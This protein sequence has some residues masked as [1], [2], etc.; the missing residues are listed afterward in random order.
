[1]H[2]K[3]FLLRLLWRFDRSLLTH[4][5]WQTLLWPLGL[6]LILLLLFWIIGLFWPASP[7][8][9]AT[10]GGIPRWAETSGLFLSGGQFP[11]HSP[12]PLLLQLIIVIAGS[13]L[14]AAFLT[15]SVTTIL[16]NRRDN[17]LHGHSRYYFSNHILVL[18]GS[19]VVLQLLRSLDSRPDLQ[20]KPWVILTSADA[21]T[22]RDLIHTTL[23]QT[24]HAIPLV[25]Y[26]GDP[27]DP[28]T[29]RSCQAELA[30]TIL[31][32]GED[33]D[34][35][36]DQLNIACW[37]TL[38]HQ[39]TNA[40][41]LAQCYLY[42]DRL[43]TAQMLH[44]LPPES[45]TSLETTVIN[46]FEAIARQTLVSPSPDSAHLTLDRYL[47]GP[48]STR[49]VHLI[50]VGLT[51][52]GLA[53]ASTAAQLCHY[54]NFA[55]TAARPRRTCITFVDPLAAQKMEF[56]KTRY[57]GLFQ[58][59]HITLRTDGGGW[60]SSRP[61]PAYGDFLDIEWQFLNGGVEQSWIRDQ[62][63][64]YALD[65][66]QVVSVAFCTD[67]PSH[68]LSAALSLPAPYYSLA[69][70]DDPSAVSPLIYVYQPLN[71]VLARAAQTEVPRYHNIV[72]FGMPDGTVDPFDAATTLLAKRINYI[73]HKIESGKPLTTIPSEPQS[74]NNLWC[75]L[76]IAEK[77]RAIH[78]ATL[79][80]TLMRTTR[81]L[82]DP[83]GPDPS[84][85]SP[86]D[87][88]ARIEHNRWN[89]E[90]LL[91][92]YAPLPANQRALLNQA[93]ACDDPQTRQEAAILNKRHANLRHTLKD[94]APFDDLPADL[95]QRYRAIVE[96]YRRAF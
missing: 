60:Q 40:T 34:P 16:L 26:H 17:L 52:M 84:A 76:S 50:V 64:S 8:T 13:A 42:I 32:T 66:Q 41:L 61:D 94:I 3:P 14:M 15:G 68:N 51:P 63:S 78:A 85:P 57:P 49:R 83:D 80:D 70:A 90:M 25:I 54:P 12:L 95:Q 36:H 73:H 27:T 69:D 72:P 71:A 24:R 21:A 18:G 20:G 11:L 82:S 7:L 38:R 47:L 31:I 67:N 39:R 93:L 74:L 46:R 59:S 2:I 1:M 9:L 96:Q 4:R 88:L 43:F 77:H 37:N 92:N 86:T 87:L 6:G 19:Q 30:S 44:D 91:D 29:L 89:M 5:A 75:Q 79:V 53:F 33:G 23:P 55:T 81:S 28:S 56:F 48:D 62:L 58:L 10:S 45:H 22:L 35:Q 65:E